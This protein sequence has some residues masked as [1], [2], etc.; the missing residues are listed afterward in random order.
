MKLSL[1]W[2]F[3]LLYWSLDHL[4]LTNSEDRLSL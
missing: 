3:G 4:D 1:S 2:H